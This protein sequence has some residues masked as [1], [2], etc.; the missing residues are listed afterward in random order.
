[1]KKYTQPPLC[2]KKFLQEK[3][4]YKNKN[5]NKKLRLTPKNVK[6]RRIIKRYN[7]MDNNSKYILGD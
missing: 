5:K 4:V 1:M 7:D 2:A 3:K 6:N